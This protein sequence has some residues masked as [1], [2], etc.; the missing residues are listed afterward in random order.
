MRSWSTFHFYP[1]PIRLTFDFIFR[2]YSGRWLSAF[3]WIQAGDI[4]AI[5]I[6]LRTLL[7]QLAKYQADTNIISAGYG[8]Q[9]LSII[10]EIA[11]DVK[12]VRILTSST[13]GK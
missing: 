13:L 4:V 6:H 5:F 2:S 11:Q 9:D 7:E 3:I 12:Q 8:Q 10:M 1:R